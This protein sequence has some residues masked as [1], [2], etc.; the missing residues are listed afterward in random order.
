[1]EEGGGNICPLPTFTSLPTSFQY[2]P[3]LNCL[4]SISEGCGI[5]ILD[6]HSGQITTRAEI[7]KDEGKA[8]LP[9]HFL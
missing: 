1:M 3:S 8:D 2:S 6:I 9:N 4:I 5:E 7:P